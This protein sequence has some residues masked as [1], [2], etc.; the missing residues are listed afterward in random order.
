MSRESRTPPTL[1]AG[2]TPHELAVLVATWIEEAISYA[3]RR[4]SLWARWSTT[5]R[6]VMLAV[7]STATVVLGVS[8]GDVFVRIGFVLSALVTTL[9][10]L[11]PFFNWRSRWIQAEE[12]L[13]GWYHL[14][15][16]IKLLVAA[17]PPQQ[18]T[19]AQVEKVYRRFRAVWDAWS[20][21]WVT[22]RRGAD[23]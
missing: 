23:S 6:V 8:E 19:T 22:A 3:Q 2:L 4:R 12:A 5:V 21:A 15:D 11:E 9:T 20:S 17:T 10:A 18:L 7:S 13:A 14:H 16:E 1:P